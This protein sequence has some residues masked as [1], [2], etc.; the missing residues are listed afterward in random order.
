MTTFGRSLPHLRTEIPGPRSRELAARLTRV[1]CPSFEA[2]RHARQEEA[3]ASQLPIVYGRAFGSNVACV[4][5]NVFVDLT[6]GF[7][8]L[9]LGH[10]PP[11]LSDALHGQQEV[12]P[13]AL[14]DVYAS[15]AKVVACEMI[16]ALFPEKGARVLLGSSGADA[17][18]AALKTAELATGR[19]GVL[20]FEGAYHGLSHGP[21]ALCGLSNAFRQPFTSSLS[22]HVTFLPYPD[23]DATLRAVEARAI[24]ACRAGQ[25]GAIVVEPILGRGGCI[26]PPPAFLPTLRRVADASGAL[27]VVD[28]VWTG[29]GRSGAMLASEGI[30]PDVV[31]LGKGLGAGFPVSACVGRASVMAAWGA[32][33]GTAIHTATHFGSPLACASIRTALDELAEQNLP[34]RALRI[35]ATFMQM[36]S[37]AGHR[38]TGRGLMLGI[39]LDS[40]KAALRAASELLAR[41]YIVLTGGVGGNVLTLTPAL[42]VPEALLEA[43][44]RDFSDQQK[45]AS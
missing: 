26:V 39:H 43:F 10:A 36:V 23:S 3:G 25:I 15:D 33:G 32:H 12:L 14:G 22:P 24:D 37:E 7:G 21:L 19:A 29:M 11:S 5:D 8:A 31:C 28:E 35:G 30:V 20:A 13:L 40:K 18:T 2:R 27:L 41:G 9:V 1:E 44:V 6:C 34:A 42:N 45:A 17:L 38:V 4:D 16:Q